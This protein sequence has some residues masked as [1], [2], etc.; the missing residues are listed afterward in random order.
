MW[1]KQEADVMGGRLAHRRDASSRALAGRAP[2]GCGGARVQQQ[3][4]HAVGVV[5]DWNVAPTWELE[6]A[7]VRGAARAARSPDYVVALTPGDR[8]RHS[9]ASLVLQDP[10]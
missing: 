1:S 4:R 7:R 3:F 5:P 8:D 9:D 6:I 2:R 10:V